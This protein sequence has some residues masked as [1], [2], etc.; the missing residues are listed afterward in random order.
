MGREATLDVER[1]LSKHGA[2]DSR[3]QKRGTRLRWP[4][5]CLLLFSLL[6]T[7]LLYRTTRSDRVVSVPRYLTRAKARCSQLKLKPGPPSDFGSRTVSDRFVPGTPA[8]LI[9]NAS[10]WTGGVDGL[11]IIHGDIFLDKGLIK[12]IGRIDKELVD[13]SQKDF[14]TVDAHGAWVTPG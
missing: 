13:H 2:P 10:I 14:E 11:E 4:I 12:A 3:G 8:T 5:F 9:K 6:A 1:S 7:S